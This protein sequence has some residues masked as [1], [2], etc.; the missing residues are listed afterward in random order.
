MI[1]V[2]DDIGN[3]RAEEGRE[4]GGVC[5]GERIISTDYT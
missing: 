4:G 3:A 1:K 2:I 5:R